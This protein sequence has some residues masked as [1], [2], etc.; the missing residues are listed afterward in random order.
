MPVLFLMLVSDQGFSQKKNNRF[1][2][3]GIIYSAEGLPLKSASVYIQDIKK[4]TISDSTGR[5]EINNIPF[6]N[7]LIELRFIG[8]KTFNKNIFFNQ[9]IK[10]NF[11]LELSVVEENEVIVTG[12]SKAGSI[13]RNPIPVVSI[14]R[15]Y[16]EQT[17][18]S[19]IIDAIS[20]VPGITSLSTGPNVSKPFIRG[21]GYNR[22]LTLYDGVRQEGQQWGDEHGIEI[23]Q[24]SIDKVE[25]V[26]G[27]ASLIYGSDAIAGV[28]NFL[29]ANPPLDGKISGN[30]LS[31]YQTNNREILNSASISGKRNDVNFGLIFSHKQAIDYKNKFDGRVY[32]TGFKETDLSGNLGINKHW[33]YSKI[34]FSI[35]NNLQEIPDGSRDS[36]TRKFTKQISEEDD[37]REIVSDKEL[38]SYSISDIHQHVEH[39][40]VYN[41]TN[42]IVGGG[43]LAINL[44]A[45]KSIRKEFNHPLATDVPGLS[46]KLNSYTYDLKYFF[47]EAKGMSVTAGFNG[48]IQNN[49]VNSGTEFLIPSYKQF[50]IGSFIYAK[51]SINKLEVAGGVR[52]D[53]RKFK[54]DALYISTDPATGF[55]YIVNDENIS[56]ADKIFSN[57][58]KTFSGFSGSLGLSYLLNK[59]WSLKANVSQ[60]YRAPNISE[61]SANGI[62][63]GTN[64]YQIGNSDFKPEFNLQEDI[65]I[66]YSTNHLTINA[67]AFNNSIRNYI[68]NARVLNSMGGDSAIVE[69][70]RTYKFVSSR[71]QLYGGEISIDVHPHPLDWLHF[72]NSV[73]LVYGIN[74]GVK[75]T[76]SSSDSS[77]YLPDI[78]PVRVISELRANFKKTNDFLANSFIKLEA[79]VNFKQNHPYLEN[80]SETATPAYVLINAGLGSEIINK[81]GKTIFRVNILANNILNKAYQS[82]LSRLKN[83]EE[84]PKNS[85]GRS[86]I[87]NIGSNFSLNLNIPFTM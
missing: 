21:L 41:I 63:S 31:S 2:F 30:I 18:S 56:G 29:P 72:E 80:G 23:D 68:Y 46:L 45:Q 43:R 61:I 7:Y 64:I 34:G 83:F 81:K 74:K 14:G 9:D 57:Y 54:N 49:N 78:P 50:D 33:G 79:D 77:Y 47:H 25:I 36:S 67:S 52:Y 82:H 60:G 58:K 28:V 53:V 5:F 69:G 59:Q 16:L 19:N 35:F 13:K 27:P 85:T 1:T 87:Y 11:N 62:H 84:Y 76:K 71:A 73:S 20:K 39:F 8:Y 44:G 15:K 40:R 65:S 42:F 37:V 51:K 12:T 48:M 86:G 6:G 4:G 22:I 17:L 3:S 26:K 32:N 70:S 38:N 10:Q 75:N 55:N 66:N 24:N